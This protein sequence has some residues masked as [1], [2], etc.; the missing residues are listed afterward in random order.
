MKLLDA[1]PTYRPFMYPKAY[2]IWELAQKSHWMHHEVQMGG[3]V[4]DWKFQMSDTDR[5]TIGSILKSF[6]QAEIFVEEFWSGFVAKKF[7]HPE[8]QMMANTFA[9]FETIHIAG[10]AYLNDSLGLDDYEAF[11]HEP[12]AKAKIDRLMAKRGK[13]KQD[14]ARSLA[15]FS[16]FTEGVSLFSSFCI[17]MSFAQRNL[18]KGVGQIVAWSIRDEQ[19]HSQAGCW[20][21]R[22]FVKEYPDVLTEELKKE[23][24]EA[25]RLTIDLEDAFIDKAFEKGD[26]PN[27]SASDLKVYM[28]FRANS[29]L[30]E[31]GLKKNWKNLDMDA[32]KR[33]EWFSVTANGVEHPDF[34]AARATEYAKSV[35]SFD[36]VWED[37]VPTNSESPKD[38]GA[39]EIS[40]TA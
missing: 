7:K 31:L 30:G 27:L 12:T 38:V 26:L 3:D 37:K 23:I 39:N 13:A 19:L 24:Y 28:R 5:H 40:A 1:R 34:F 22:E 21:F 9:G 36:N 4:N 6:V 17:L 10:Y 25:A 2:D 33:L 32:V 16:A 20:L 18:M 15:I 11:L 35:L 8:I 29:K 14:I